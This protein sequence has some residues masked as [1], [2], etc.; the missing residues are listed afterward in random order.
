MD[1]NPYGLTLEPNLEAIYNSEISDL[2]ETAGVR[3]DFQG[4][5]GIT[6][7]TMS[8]L[9]PA[10]KIGVVISNGR[11][12]S[13]IKYKELIYDLWKQ[14]DFSIYI[15]DHRGQGLSGRMLPNPQMGYVRDFGDYVADLKTFVDTVVKP[16]GHQSLALLAHS[17]GGAIASLYLEEFP[18]DFAVSV[19]SA[20]MHEPEMTRLIPAVLACD[21][22]DVKAFIGH[23]EHWPKGRGPYKEDERFEDQHLTHSAVRYAKKR[24]EFA[25][26]LDAKLGD[27]TIGWALAACDASERARRTA[28][29]IRVPVLILQAGEDIAV[30]PEGQREFCSTMNRARPD[31]CRIEIFPG[32][33][34][35]LLHERD[36]YRVPAVTQAINFIRFHIH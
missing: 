10:S 3:R 33:Y 8:F 5:A 15:L 1:S 7:A 11:T 25:I 23:E 9:R 13:F 34:H 28:G 31:S 24:Q 27:A 6:I 16:A 2:W 36:D 22:L 30:K 4:V 17:M 12:E 18:N 19:L 14:P 29:Q 26:N 32:A 20:P 21:L 35:E